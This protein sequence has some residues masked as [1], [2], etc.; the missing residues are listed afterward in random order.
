MTAFI[1][2]IVALIIV[3]ALMPKPQLE[4]ARAGKLGDFSFPRASEGSPVPIIFG[5]VR[6][7]SPNVL[8][9]GDLVVVAITEKVKTGLFSDKRVTTGYKYYLGM[10]LGLCLGSGVKLLRIWAGKDVAWQ[11][12]QS[13]EGD[14]YINKPDLFGGEKQRGGLQGYATFYPGTFTQ[15]QNAYLVSKCDPNVPRYGGISHLVFKSFYFGTQTSIS[16]LNFELQRFPNALGTA[17]SVMPNGLDANP[18]E[19]LYEAMTGRWG[20][21]G[22]TTNQIDTANWQAVA[23]TVYNEG[24]GMSFSVQRANKGKD[25]ADEV[26]R[27]IESVMYQDPETGK[28][29]LKLIRNDFVLANLPILDVS[30]VKSVRTF[31]KSTWDSTYNQVRIKYP[32]REKDY[33]DGAATAQDFANI[34]FQQRVK[35]IEVSFPG[36]TYPALAGQLAARALSFYSVPLYKAELHCTRAVSTL[37]PGD[38]FVLQWAPFNIVTMV[39]RAQRVDLGDLV[40]GSITVDCIQDQ[41]AASTMIFAP[42]E[43]SLWDPVTMIALPVV[44]RTMMESPFFF[45]NASGRGAEVNVNATTFWVGAKRPGV[46]SMTYDAE[47]TIDAYATTYISLDDQVYLPTAQLA[48]AYSATEG[49]T[50][51]TPW[52]D[53]TVGLV[54]NNLEDATV[55]KA[56]SRTDSEDGRCLLVIGSELL[57]YTSYTNNGDGTYTLHNI[58]R[59]ILDSTPEAHIVGD[60][61]YFLEGQEGLME[62]MFTNSFTVTTRLRDQTPTSILP[63]ADA[64]TNSLAPAY[65]PF[66]AIRPTSLTINASRTPAAVGPGATSVTVAWNRRNRNTTSIQWYNDVD[67]TPETNQVTEVQYS[68]NGG[69][70]TSASTTQTGTSYALDVTGMVGTLQVRVG[71]IRDSYTSR[72]YSDTIAITLL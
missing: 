7:N 30:K 54:I 27:H 14:I 53:T 64:L 2:F 67:E 50:S 5:T 72:G 62:T 65:R 42:P 1:Y 63:V 18:V 68:L 20:E 38:A 15:G 57:S 26:L 44:T 60:T 21:L 22:M 4:D 13:A 47:T 19:I 45:L 23:Q 43:S 28:I 16:A 17:Y 25:I 31:S 32:N 24:L 9:Y 52:Y 61:V 8:W 69:A 55:L 37:R 33:V 39:M 51:A 66:R 40:D 3:E 49:Q 56:V 71:A 11:G 6:L 48:V 34:N 70:W 29:K 46:A 58:S 36:C 41:F 59:Y 12:T 35:N 10:D